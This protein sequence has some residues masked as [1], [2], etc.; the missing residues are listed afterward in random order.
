MHPATLRPPALPSTGGSARNRIL[1][2]T[3]S[4]S[5][6]PSTT[7]SD[8]D[9]GVRAPPTTASTSARTAT[10]RWPASSARSSSGP[11]A[12]I[13]IRTTTEGRTH[14]D[15]RQRDTGFVEVRAVLPPDARSAQSDPDDRPHR[16]PD[17]RSE[18]HTSELQSLMRISYAVF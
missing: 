10:S 9:A 8:Q 5:P 1:S 3:S 13:P 6:P 17:H 14:D 4:I 7:R 11:E 12:H 18:E 2:S 16:G 15:D